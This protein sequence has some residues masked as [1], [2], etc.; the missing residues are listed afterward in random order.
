M[1]ANI[2]FIHNQPL[3]ADKLDHRI[4]YRSLTDDK[5]AE[6]KARSELVYSKLRAFVDAH[7]LKDSTLQEL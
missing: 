4:V 5:K 6:D 1:P 7:T 2:R 3:S